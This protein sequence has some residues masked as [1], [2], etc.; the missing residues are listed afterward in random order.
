M[1]PRPRLGQQLG[2]VVAVIGVVDI[3]QRNPQ[4]I[5]EQVEQAVLVDHA[6]FDQ[7]TAKLAAELFLF[8]ERVLKLFLGN[9]ALFDE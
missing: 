3:D 5:G 8:A 1:P 9:Q 7:G 6:K 4:L 2:D